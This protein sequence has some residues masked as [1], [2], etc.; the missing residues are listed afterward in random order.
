[1]PRLVDAIA[2][3]AARLRRPGV[4]EARFAPAEAGPSFSPP[5]INS[6]M[7]LPSRGTFAPN[8]IIGSDFYT[9]AGQYRV[10]QR[11]SSPPPAPAT[12]TPRTPVA[13]VNKRLVAPTIGGGTKLSRYNVVSTVVSPQAV[14]GGATVTQ[15]FTAAGVQAADK[16][17]GYQWVTPQLKGVTVLAVRI[18][19]ANQIAIDFF[20]PMAGSL[21]PT[22][23]TILLFLV[24]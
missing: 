1:M 9:G 13:L 15:L 2:A 3:N 24:Q 22:G 6:P 11:S 20:N 23:G 21:T 19:A 14:G 16:L 7:G 5:P 12:S 10:A 8:V 17:L 18:N 4:S